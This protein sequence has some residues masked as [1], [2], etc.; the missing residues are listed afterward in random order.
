MGRHP[1]PFTLTL[2]ISEH[3]H[4]AFLS[5]GFDRPAAMSGGDFFTQ[6]D[7][8]RKSGGQRFGGFLRSNYAAGKG[9]VTNG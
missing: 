2:H 4:D 3:C 6:G 8:R 7:R 5:V 9:I 1:K